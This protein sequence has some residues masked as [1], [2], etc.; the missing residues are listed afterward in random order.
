MLLLLQTGQAN[1]QEQRAEP[2]D[3]EKLFRRHS[4]LLKPTA[5]ANDFCRAHIGSGTQATERKTI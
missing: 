3:F 2:G 5:K 4:F 1:L